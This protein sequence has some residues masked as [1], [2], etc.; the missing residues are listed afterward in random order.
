MVIAV[1]VVASN[2]SVSYADPSHAPVISDFVVIE[3]AP[4]YWTISGTVTDIDYDVEGMPVFFGGVLSGYGIEGIVEYDGSFSLTVELPGLQ[5]GTATAQTFDY[6]ENYSN[7]A[8][9]L[10]FAD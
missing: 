3:T 4:G 10:V 5:S 8:E 9:A 1:V 7:M 6:S 2:G